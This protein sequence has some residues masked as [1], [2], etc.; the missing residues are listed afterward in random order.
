MLV[1]VVV[2]IHASTSLHNTALVRCHKKIHKLHSNSGARK[3]NAL[4]GGD[5]RRT[6]RTTLRSILW[7][8][9]PLLYLS[10]E[11]VY[12]DVKTLGWDKRRQ[13]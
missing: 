13:P 6:R 9:L 10:L 1:V 12:L 3:K 4:I 7:V 2:A 11:A 5:I 8:Y